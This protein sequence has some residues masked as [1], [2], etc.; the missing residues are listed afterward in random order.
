MP[1]EE[2]KD[3]FLAMAFRKDVKSPR[4]STKSETKSGEMSASQ[5]KQFETAVN[6]RIQEIGIKEKQFYYI[7]ENSLRVKLPDEWVQAATEDGFLYY[8]NEKS[9][10]SI[11]THPL[12]DQF[13][14]Q[15]AQAMLMQQ[16]Q[17]QRNRQEGQGQGGEAKNSNNSIS[18][19]SNS[20]PKSPA[21]WGN[22]EE[23]SRGRSRS[24]RVG[25]QTGRSD[26]SDTSGSRSRSGSSGGSYYTRSRSSSLGSQSEGSFV[27]SPVVRQV[28]SSKSDKQQQGSNR[29]GGDNRGQGSS[30]RSEQKQKTQVQAEEDKGYPSE[31]QNSLAFEG[32]DFEGK[33][34][35]D[36]WH[37]RFELLNRE[38]MRVQIQMESL[39][40]KLQDTIGKESQLMA[41]RHTLAYFGF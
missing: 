17:Q 28:T 4:T 26:R 23:G 38:K 9:D 27:D 13:K 36:Y 14:E 40:I 1:A 30:G 24:K 10:E 41:D 22:G 35:A 5:K 32:I 18:K 39:E 21:A 19:N 33:H 15:Y 12:L 37:E 29:G 31:M 11:W 8:F 6:R 34:P 16:Q 3:D 2:Q 25:S 7:A 20:N